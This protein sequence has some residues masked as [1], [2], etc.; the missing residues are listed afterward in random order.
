MSWG[1]EGNQEDGQSQGLDVNLRP[2]EYK[3]F[4]TDAR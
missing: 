4:V 2:T 3:V 1:C